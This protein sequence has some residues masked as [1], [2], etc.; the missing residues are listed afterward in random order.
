[1]RPPISAQQ[2]VAIS[3]SHDRS[4]AE[5]VKQGT[6]ERLI[7]QF[8]QLASYPGLVIRAFRM[9]FVLRLAEAP[10]S[11]YRCKRITLLVMTQLGDG[12]C[13]LRVD[14]FQGGRPR[15]DGLQCLGMPTPSDYVDL[16]VANRDLV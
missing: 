1:M 8:G 2:P 10:D 13:N 9:F 4:N 7:F 12:T 6:L 3:M 5:L 11:W 14:K 16:Q 15:V